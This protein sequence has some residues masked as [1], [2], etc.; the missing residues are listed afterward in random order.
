MK[1]T[2]QSIFKSMFNFLVSWGEAI[3]AYRALDKR[4]YY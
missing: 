4:I 1:S 3:H 2:I